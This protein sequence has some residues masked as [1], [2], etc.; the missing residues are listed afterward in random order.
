LAVVLLF[1]RPFET[2]IKTVLP[3]SN[4]SISE[5]GTGAGTGIAIPGHL[6]GFNVIIS[7]DLGINGL[8]ADLEDLATRQLG[9]RGVQI[10]FMHNFIKN[11]RT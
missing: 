6:Q 7:A 2:E 8:L 9:K 5:K 3:N 11:P 1:N 10:H 4:S